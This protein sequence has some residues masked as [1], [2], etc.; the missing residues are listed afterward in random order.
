MVVAKRSNNDG[1][2][3]RFGWVKGGLS[4]VMYCRLT[5]RHRPNFRK[6]YNATKCKLY[7]IQSR[8]KREDDGAV[9]TR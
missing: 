9:T 5:E 3:A 6:R 8:S 1:E 4:E 2:F 7:E